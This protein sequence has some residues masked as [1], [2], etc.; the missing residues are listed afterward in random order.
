LIERYR[1]YRFGIE[2]ARAVSA[3][4][5][6]DSAAAIFSQRLLEP[7][8]FIGLAGAAFIVFTRF[9]YLYAGVAAVCSPA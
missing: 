7:A 8:G 9:G 2:E 5:S 3:C 4:R 1:V 6:S